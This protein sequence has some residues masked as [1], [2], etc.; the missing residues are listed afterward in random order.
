MKNKHQ[1]TDKSEVY[2]K[3]TKPN[4]II[5]FLFICSTCHMSSSKILK[6]QNTFVLAVS[7]LTT[8]LKVNLNAVHIPISHNLRDSIQLVSCH[9]IFS[10]LN[11]LLCFFYIL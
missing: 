6:L 2:Y 10:D 5:I 8:H 9:F 3:P 7:V 4:L 1:T 11:N